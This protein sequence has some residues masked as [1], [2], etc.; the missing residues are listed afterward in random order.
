[1]DKNALKEWTILNYANGNNEYEPEMY[2]A[3][4]DSEMAECNEKINIVMEIGRI[5]REV[6]RIIR[7]SE[8]IMD[9]YEMWTGV[10]R[11]VVNHNKSELIEDLGSVNMAD[12]KSLYDFI[13]WGIKNYPAKHYAL[14]LGGHGAS[15]VGTLTDYSQESP[16]I[17]GTAEMCKAVNM[18]LKDTG[19]KIDILN[20]GYMLYESCRD[21]V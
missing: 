21:Y 4:K 1:M 16:Y 5:D 15:F 14:I 13:I 19:C 20:F 12:P 9:D 17:M 8:K 2:R 10:R 3:L 18:I 6:V 11:Y 7:P